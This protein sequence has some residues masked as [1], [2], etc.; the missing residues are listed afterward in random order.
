MQ[1]KTLASGSTGNA[2]Y[3]SAGQTSL[4]L[5]CGIPITKIKQGLDYRLSET[6]ACL[7]THEHLDHAKCWRDISKAGINLIMSKGTAEALGA[8]GHRII[9]ATLK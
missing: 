3:V 9:I 1:I 5:E 2:Y 6:A 4:L 7:V 8:D